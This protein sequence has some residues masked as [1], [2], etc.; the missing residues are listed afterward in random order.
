MITDQTS[1]LTTTL[2]DTTV[3]TTF[4]TERSTAEGTSTMSAGI[5][6]TTGT[7]VTT[8]VPVISTVTTEKFEPTVTSYKYKLL[9]CIE[10]CIDHY[11]CDA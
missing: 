11:E 1:I 5:E 3:Q 6:S 7:Q 8:E 2:P 9:S 10:D 4:Q